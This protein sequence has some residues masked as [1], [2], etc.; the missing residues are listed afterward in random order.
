MSAP[1]IFCFAST[2]YRTRL[3]NGLAAPDETPADQPWLNQEAVG[4]RNQIT[5]LK[6]PNDESYGFEYQNT[7]PSHLTTNYMELSRLN[8]PT[9]GSIVYRWQETVE[10]CYAKS[11][12]GDRFATSVVERDVYESASSSPAVWK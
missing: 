1:I 8:L 4:Y 6:L 9:G 10:T 7:D 12:I 5:K 2:P 11:T 3:F